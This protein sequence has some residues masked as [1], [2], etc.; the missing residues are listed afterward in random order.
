MPN[1]QNFTFKIVATNEQA[2]K[3]AADGLE[4]RSYILNAR[5]SLDKGAI[6]FCLFVGNELASKGGWP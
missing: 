1:T 5:R 6:V 4:F 2:N 3:L